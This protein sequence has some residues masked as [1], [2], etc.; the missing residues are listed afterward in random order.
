MK[1]LLIVIAMA[2]SCLLVAVANII[3]TRT[4]GVNPFTFKIWFIIPVGAVFVGMLGTSGSILAARYFNIHPKPFDM[5]LMVVVA[6]A[7]MVFIY[8]LDYAT[9]V[10]QDGRKASA[11]IGFSDYVDTVLTKS[12]MRFGRGARDVGEVGEMGHWLAGAEFI[13]FLVGGLATF[14]FIKGFARCFDCDSYLRKLKTKM[15][16]ELT[17]GETEKLLHHFKTGDL[18]TVKQVLAWKGTYQFSEPDPNDGKAIITYDL[19]GCPKCKSEL[20]MANPK[21]FNGKEWKVIP[22]LSSS[23]RLEPSLSLRASF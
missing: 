13:G 22:A 8:Y 7:T 10:L 5:V 18:A 1:H 17:F 9:F 4:I 15:S 20:V 12:H 3:I 21:A 2:I 11:L 6:A 19:Y 14:C 16:P 23:R